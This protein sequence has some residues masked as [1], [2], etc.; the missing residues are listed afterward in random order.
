MIFLQTDPYVHTCPEIPVLLFLCDHRL[1]CITRSEGVHFSLH[2][3]MSWIV[4]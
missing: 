3:C 1:I 4:N 2:V